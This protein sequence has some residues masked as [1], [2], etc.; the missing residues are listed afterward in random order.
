MPR[1]ARRSYGRLRGD[2]SD[3][4]KETTMNL[5]RLSVTAAAALGLSALA[6]APA[7]A[8]PKGETIPLTCGGVTY[9]VAVN[10]DGDF[11]PA[12]D[13]ASTRMFI[14]VWFGPFH[15]TVTDASGTVIDEF[16]DPAMTKGAG[17]NAD[18][19]CSYTFHDT[20]EDPELGTLTF[21][22]SGTVRGFVTP[23]R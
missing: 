18:L 5:R 12:H 2:H 1:H 13:T 23:R 21:D 6:A 4:G 11:T 10:G 19:E 3:P 8:D 17:K 16:T 22:G 7:T 14:P 20:F 9:A 15:G